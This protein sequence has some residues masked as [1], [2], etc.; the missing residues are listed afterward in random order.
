MTLI[1]KF[2][3]LIHPATQRVHLSKKPKEFIG[4]QQNTALNE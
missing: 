1:Q 3:Y 2:F 4:F